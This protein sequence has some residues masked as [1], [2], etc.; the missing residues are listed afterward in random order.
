MQ[1]DGSNLRNIS[2][3][4]FSER[5]PSWSGDGMKLTF[6]S[7]RKG[8]EVSSDWLEWIGWKLISPFTGRMRAVW[9]MDRDGQHQKP[10]LKLPSE[11]KHADFSPTGD[12]IAFESDLSGQDQ[13]YITDPTGNNL[14]Q[15][16]FEGVNFKPVFRPRRP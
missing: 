7:I 1:P 11:L 4:Q 15:V 6:T 13:V 3:N 16:T 2:D 14:R 5:Y 12:A 8:E 10:L 9:T